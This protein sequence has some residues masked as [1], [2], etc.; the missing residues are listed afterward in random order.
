MKADWA[1]SPKTICPPHNTKLLTWQS[2]MTI[3]VCRFHFHAHALCEQ[4]KLYRM[5]V[6]VSDA[7]NVSLLAIDKLPAVEPKVP[8]QG[9]AVLFSS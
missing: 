5:D 9:F 4:I 7:S 3:A 6:V 8:P 2:D 1:R